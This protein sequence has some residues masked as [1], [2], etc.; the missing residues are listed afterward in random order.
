MFDIVLFDRARS[1]ALAAREV[2]YSIANQLADLCD[3]YGVDPLITPLDS[4]EYPDICKV[5]RLLTSCARIEDSTR[6]TMAA[7]L[8][9][10]YSAEYHKHLKEDVLNMINR[11]DAHCRAAAARAAS[12][13]SELFV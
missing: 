12:L 10:N 13:E 8:A 9:Y 1:R 3:A 11:R 7:L 4:C 6:Q 2:W 5:S